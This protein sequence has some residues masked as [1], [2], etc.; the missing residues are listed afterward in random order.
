MSV[1]VSERGEGGATTSHTNAAGKVASSVAMGE[2]VVEKVHQGGVGGSSEG[3]ATLSPLT[4]GL[5]SDD[6]DNSRDHV[7]R[8]SPKKD[9]S[10]TGA[11]ANV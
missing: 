4:R 5:L 7:D 3:A 9:S 1:S 10:A 11:G 2:G 8:A 6:D